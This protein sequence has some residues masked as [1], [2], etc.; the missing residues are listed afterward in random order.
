MTSRGTSIH[1]KE[2]KTKG[3]RQSKGANQMKEDEELKNMES[4]NI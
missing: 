3:E 1:L 2:A 4:R